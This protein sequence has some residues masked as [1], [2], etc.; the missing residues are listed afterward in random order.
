MGP[1]SWESFQGPLM[2]HQTQLPI[3]FC[4]IGFLFIDDCAPF[5]FLRSW[6]LMAPYLCSRFRIFDRPVLEEYVYQVEGGPH[7]LQSC[8]RVA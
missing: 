3:S 7:L 6:A 5:V 1:E 8:L 4:G 2:R